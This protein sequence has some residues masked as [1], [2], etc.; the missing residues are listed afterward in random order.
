MGGRRHLIAA[1]TA[2]A[3]AGAA[4]LTGEPASAPPPVDVGG[5]VFGDL[6]DAK[7][8][9]VE[10]YSPG[11][12]AN[13]GFAFDGT[14]TAIDPG[15]GSELYD[16]VTFRIHRWYRNGSRDHAFVA[17]PRAAAYPIGSRMLVSGEAGGDPRTHVA[18]A[19][20]FTRWFDEREADRWR[21][22]FGFPLDSRVSR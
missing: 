20:G 22:T 11:A 10:S 5:D 18:W 8:S 9:C 21:R 7:L 4:V 12:L 16:T 3:I 6:P 17:M 1:L 19:C 15:S 13:R 2:I 14:V